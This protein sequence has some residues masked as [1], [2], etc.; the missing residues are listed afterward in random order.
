MCSNDD[1]NDVTH[2][3]E[4]FMEVMNKIEDWSHYNTLV[5]ITG[6]CNDGAINNTIINIVSLSDITAIHIM[7]AYTVYYTIHH[8]LCT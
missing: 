6:E 5:V 1:Y 3:H 2:Y 7:Q 4:S 8:K